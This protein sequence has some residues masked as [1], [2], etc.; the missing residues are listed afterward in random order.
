MPTCF[1]ESEPP[2]QNTCS[3]CEQGLG[4]RVLKDV[5]VGF[6]EP[7]WKEANSCEETENC[8]SPL[9]QRNQTR[10]WPN[11]I[12]FSSQSALQFAELLPL[13]TGCQVEALT[14][15]QTHIHMGSRN[16]YILVYF[17]SPFWSSFWPKRCSS[18]MP[19]IWVAN[20]MHFL[21]LSKHLCGCD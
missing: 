11:C 10:I 9:W 1:S 6:R 7:C 17:F 4:S 15:T 20:P 14:H 21:P 3:D 19:P 5:F 18:N 16:Q 12:Y 13:I 8:I 2:C